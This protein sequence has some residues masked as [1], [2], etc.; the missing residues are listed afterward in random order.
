M[1]T[2]L[3]KEKTNSN[4]CNVMQDRRSKKFLI[5]KGSGQ[6]NIITTSSLALADLPRFTGVLLFAL[7]PA[8]IR[9]K[10]IQI[11]T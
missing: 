6:E 10:Q 11:V 3:L 5:K 1:T 4:N 8:E 2:A 9:T 7:V